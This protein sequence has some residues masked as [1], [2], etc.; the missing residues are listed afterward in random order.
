MSE[1]EL[2]GEIEIGT[3]EEQ[4]YARTNSRIDNIIAHNNDTEG[5]SELIDIRTGADGTVYESA[6]AAVRSQISGISDNCMMTKT[7]GS[8]ITDLNNLKQTGIYFHGTSDSL[9]D[10][11]P[12][13][14]NKGFMVEVYYAGSD[15]RLYQKI[16][17]YI[18]NNT[19]IRGCMVSGTWNAWISIATVSGMESAF[20]NYSRTNVNNKSVPPSAASINDITSTGVYYLT[21]GNELSGKPSNI[22]VL[23]V[24]TD[25]N[26]PTTRCYQT[27]I[28]YS[29]SSVYVRNRIDSSDWRDWKRIADLGESFNY[30]SASQN[31][32]SALNAFTAYFVSNV[33]GLPSG[34]SGL[35]LNFKQSNYT[36]RA[37]QV[38]MPYSSD[39]MYFRHMVSGTYGAWKRVLTEDDMTVRSKKGEIV[40][41]GTG[42]YYIHFGGFTAKLDRVDDDTKNSHLW[43][44]TQI[45][46]GND[47]LVPSGTDI[48]GPIQESGESDFM[49][50]VHGDEINTAFA[51]Y[52]DGALYDMK[53]TV[54]FDTL[55]ICMVS[56]IQRVSTKA[57][58]FARIVNIRIAGNEMTISSQYKALV[59]NITVSRATNGGLIAVRN[60]IINGIYMNN[61]FADSAPTESISNT[62]KENTV[63][64]FFTT[65]GTI[66]VENIIGHENEKYRGR[67]KVF[68][69]ESPVRTKSYFDVISSD[70]V[71]NTGDLITGVFR[72]TFG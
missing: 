14:S 53:S 34:I 56:N 29:D 9:P 1:I 36:T 49:G 33:T 62:S 35:V 21:S 17:D 27:W 4:A 28:S 43:N 59:D 51:I 47:I 2:T 40:K 57:N 38:Y 50:G 19:Y 72:Y 52:A 46:K 65:L 7:I 31:D 5:N 26:L 11:S 60:N 18:D 15:T 54:Y 3:S 64:K 63:A 70:T 42:S 41:N 22:G 66:T 37:Y 20:S 10:N 45:T 44:I 69:N 58:V 13:Q 12:F 23:I 61:Y 24:Y 16:I 8:N 67:W 25:A 6:G 68:T 55:D 48:I 30:D 39:D 71:F 32:V